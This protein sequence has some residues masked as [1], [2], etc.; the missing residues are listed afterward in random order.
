VSKSNDDVNQ[1]TATPSPGGEGRGEGELNKSGPQSAQNNN[2]Y[3]G[4]TTQELIA[5]C[6]DQ[7]AQKKAA[8]LNA[9]TKD[10]VGT[11]CGASDPASLSQR[12][13][14]GVRENT[15]N[16]NPASVSEKGENPKPKPPLSDYEKALL[17][18]KTFNEAFYLQSIPAK[19]MAKPVDASPYKASPLDAFSDPVDAPPR[20]IPQP[21]M[22]PHSFRPPPGYNTLG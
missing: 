12:E 18:G 10:M 9:S 11:R 13:R 4:K 3:A 20:P 19:L 15:S 2:P 17:E 22:P 21:P 7:Y 8:R 14:G 6:E 5:E 1:P 16:E